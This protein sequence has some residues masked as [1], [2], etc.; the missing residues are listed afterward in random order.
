ME[1]NSGCR[2]PSMFQVYATSPGR[3]LWGSTSITVPTR[4][5]VFSSATR[6]RAPAVKRGI[7]FSIFIMLHVFTPAHSADGKITPNRN[8]LQSGCIFGPLS[9][10]LCLK[11]QI[12]QHTGATASLQSLVPF[13]RVIDS[14]YAEGGCVESSQEHKVSE[15]DD[16]GL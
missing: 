15:R 6:T 14:T 3:W 11:V 8:F 16:D 10:V 4:S 9:V 7:L 12:Y 1:S 5:V 2:E 13:V